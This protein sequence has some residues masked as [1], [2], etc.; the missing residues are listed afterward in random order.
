[1]TVE[2]LAQAIASLKGQFEDHVE[3][4]NQRAEASATTL[5]N[6][7]DESHESHAILVELKRDIP[8]QRALL[9]VLETR[10]RKLELNGHGPGSAD[11]APLARHPYPSGLELE[12][13]GADLTPAGGIRIEQ[14]MW[15]TIVAAR[16]Q[17]EKAI[18]DL[19]MQI[20]AG[21]E[22]RAREKARREGAENERKRVEREAATALK[23]SD[24]NVKRWTNRFKLMMLVGGPTLSGLGAVI[25][26]LLTHH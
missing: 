11:P 9:K 7:A 6:L 12:R 5:R 19:R 20:E 26:W 21:D 17:T 1:M 25:H 23:R 4:E 3:T 14:A 10:V 18:S 24:D 8:A 2:M 22:D 15:S 16:E 13:Y